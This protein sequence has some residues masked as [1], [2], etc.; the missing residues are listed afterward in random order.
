[1]QALVLLEHA[2]ARKPGSPPLRLALAALA[3]LLHLP[4]RA[5][6]QAAALQLRQVQLDALAHHTL[7]ALAALPDHAH[8]GGLFRQVRRLGR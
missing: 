7:P 2:V 8:A 3:S 6:A 4:A 5:L 1:M